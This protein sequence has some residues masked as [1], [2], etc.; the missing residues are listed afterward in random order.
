MKNIKYKTEQFLELNSKT[1]NKSGYQIS[2]LFI[3]LILLMTSNTYAQFAGG[4]GTLEDPYQIANV[5][6][7]QLVKDYTT[8]NFVL[9]NN[10]DAT[11]TFTWNSGSG[12]L[13]IGSISTYFRGNFNGAGYKITGLTINRP[14][15]D[16]ASLFGIQYTG[17]ISNLSLENVSIVG[18]RKVGALVGE[19]MSKV[20][21]CSASGTIT[22]T[23]N[24]GGLVGINHGEIVSCS[25]SCN[26]SGTSKVGGLI[27]SGSGTGV[28]YCHA[29]GDVSGTIQ[30]GGFIG[31]IDSNGGIVQNCY[32]TANVSTTSTM[33]TLG[34][35]VGRMV[36][37]TISSCYATGNVTGGINN[38]GF[39][40]QHR[41]IIEKSYS[42]GSV[43]VQAG[44]TV[45]GFVAQSES[46][47]INNC[48]STSNVTKSS[49]NNSVGY[50]GGFVGNNQKSSTITNAY[51]AGTVFSN[52]GPV[53]GF[54]GSNEISTT[55][56][57]PDSGK[58]VNSYWN[59]DISG[60]TVGVPNSSANA[61]NTKVTGL[62]TASMRQMASFTAWDFASIWTIDEGTTY[63]YFRS[64]PLTTSL[65]DKN[66]KTIERI[67][68]HSNKFEQSI[69]IHGI[70]VSEGI[71]IE[72][73]SIDG[74]MVFSKKTNS[75]TIDISTLKNG[76]YLIELSDKAGQLGVFKFIK[77]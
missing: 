40:G 59:I 39:V 55:N 75:S 11:A 5:T 56:N 29:T 25:S 65:F 60:Q 43:A 61:V 71:N 74:K 51:S 70:D 2:G 76:I 19:M 64:S 52:G 50:A 24:V 27:G 57:L 49:L 18:K 62:S 22:G 46:G 67:K 45:G 7:L 13:P 3:G 34:G 44:A 77:N 28:N 42:T 37:G 63:P 20:E 12:F 54:A 35:F 6:Q 26:I 38:G 10:I 41:G 31:G 30:A 21:N 69:Q 9:I 48:Y 4:V 1:E 16:W 58:I 8:S 32:S 66:T 53:G 68:I 17:L 47:N 15:T 72:I 23:E 36:A 14:N 73:I 33:A